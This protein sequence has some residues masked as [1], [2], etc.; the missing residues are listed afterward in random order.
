M[1]DELGPELPAKSISML[2]TSGSIVT[3]VTSLITSPLGTSNDVSPT[4]VPPGRSLIAESGIL[5][6][7]FNSEQGGGQFLGD[8]DLH[9]LFDPFILNPSNQ[10]ASLTKL[11]I[12]KILD[13]YYPL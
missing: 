6:L 8:I 9:L 7:G 12:K 2:P 5:Y 1:P 3:A 4:K 10:I 13:L 11:Q